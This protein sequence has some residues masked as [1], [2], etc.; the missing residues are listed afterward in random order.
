M[1][2]EMSKRAADTFSRIGRQ[3]LGATTKAMSQHMRQANLVMAES[4]TEVAAAL[5][6]VTSA[7]QKYNEANKTMTTI[8][9]G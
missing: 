6:K 2:D 5:S 4:H 3:D 1:L 7:T 9:K 8:V